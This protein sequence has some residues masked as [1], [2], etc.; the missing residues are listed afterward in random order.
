MK[1]VAILGATSAIAQAAAEE[2]AQKGVSLRL[3]ARDEEKLEVVKRH[4]STVLNMTIDTRTLDL[5]DVP[6]KTD[7]FDGVDTVLIAYGVLGDEDHLYNPTEAKKILD[8][9]T[10]STIQWCLLALKHFE[11]QGKGTL[12]VITSVAGDRGRQGN[13]VYGASK[14]A[15]S[16]FLAGLR[17]KYH[18]TDIAICDIRPGFVA[19]PMTAHLKQGLLFASPETVGKAVACALKRKKPVTYTP[20]FWRWIMLVIRSVPEW[21]F[22]KTS[23]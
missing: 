1:T 20:W 19:T 3:V 16:A 12:G 11:E 4:I 7:L 22:N 6:E 18:G 17:Q 23:I 21:M 13:P 10:V 2:L 8:A 5:T 15:V 9:N 14:A